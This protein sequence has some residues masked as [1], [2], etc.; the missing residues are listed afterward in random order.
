MNRQY[1]C[2][3]MMILLLLSFPLFGQEEASNGENIESVKELFQRV[4]NFYQDPSESN[5]T[6][7][8]KAMVKFQDEIQERNRQ[9]GI[10]NLSATFLSRASQE[11]EFPLDGDGPIFEL[12]NEIIN[13][14]DTNE[15]AKFINDDSNLLPA[16]IDV[17]W[18]SFYATG[19]EKYLEQILT[20]TLANEDEGGIKTVI[21]NSA[22]WSFKS[23]CKQHSKVHEFAKQASKDDQWNEFHDFLAEC[24][25]Q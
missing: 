23:N 10:M 1:I 14:S 8:Q 6:S 21:A 5:F 7:I 13:E 22:R 12:A 3:P 18:V 4:T 20:Q 15:T 2:F 25:E 24:I 19:D 17:W 11:N 16:K 9:N